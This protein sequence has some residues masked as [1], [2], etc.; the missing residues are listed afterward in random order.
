M[1]KIINYKLKIKDIFKA[2]YTL[3]IIYF[4][5]LLVIIFM[6][7]SY[8]LPV[9]TSYITRDQLLVNAYGNKAIS[10]ATAHIFDVNVKSLI[11]FLLLLLIIT[12]VWLA[13]MYHYNYEKDLERDAN[14]IRWV[15]TGITNGLLMVIIG[16]LGGV[17]DLLTLLILF[18][19]PI[20][21]NTFFII[22]EQLPNQIKSIDGL[23]NTL[24]IVTALLPPIIILCYV[25]SADIYGTHGISTYYYYLFA[26]IIVFYAG[27]LAN[28]RLLNNKTG[29]WNKYIYSEQMHIIL[30]FIVVTAV[31]WQVFAGVLH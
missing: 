19:L 6:A 21:T 4:A 24:K 20:L 15:Q 17:Y 10:A 12:Y 29:N 13:T 16:L 1:E 30:D 25:I 9:S 27:T 7:K 11:V 31:I 22:K 23:L 8:I 14:P 18:I 5:Q 2:N 26:T 3:S 28:Q